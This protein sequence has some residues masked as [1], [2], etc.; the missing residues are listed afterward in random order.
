MDRIA[1]VIP[2]YRVEEQISRVVAKIPAFVDDVIIV[3]DCSPDGSAQVIAGIKDKRVHVLTHQKNLGVGGAMLSGYSYALT[4]DCD[5]V[6]KLDGDDQ[7]DPAYIEELIQPIRNHEADY[8]K[9]NRFLHQAELARMPIIRL[10]GNF[11]LTFLTKLAGGYW[12]VFDPTNGYTA[13]GSD[14]LSQLDP[15]RIAK[16]YF[17]ETSM[18]C[19]LRKIDAVVQDLP[20]PA[21]YKDEKSSIS[22]GRELFVFSGNLFSRFMH[23][24]IHQYFLFDF[25][26]ASL[27]LLLGTLLGLFGGI[28]GIVKWVKSI[29]TNIPATTGTVL[30]AVLPVILAVQFFTQAIALDIASVPTQ[31]SQGLENT[32]SKLTSRKMGGYFQALAEKALLVVTKK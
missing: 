13:I 4:L 20:M 22:I 14:K 3:N 1:V 31:V 11:G 16:N 10:V 8:V 32:K 19:E 7:M 26:A 28:W 21:I 6:V 9:G 23:R 17:F 18:L 27:Y 29:Q 12:N 30:L 15:N 25:N 24:L 2:A 5:I